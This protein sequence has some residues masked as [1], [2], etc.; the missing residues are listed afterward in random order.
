[1]RHNCPCDWLDQRLSWKKQWLFTQRIFPFSPG[2]NIMCPEKCWSS[3]RKEHK[4][5]YVVAR[6]HE[7]SKGRRMQQIMPS[8]TDHICSGQ[9]RIGSFLKNITH[10]RETSEQGALC[11][12]VGSYISYDSQLSSPWWALAIW[13]RALH[14]DVSTQM[15]LTSSSGSATYHLWYFRVEMTTFSRALLSG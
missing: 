1:M 2:W 11:L 14:Q 10:A 6:S 15:K 5:S 12:T 13:L 8:L 4:K 3:G 7:G 9:L